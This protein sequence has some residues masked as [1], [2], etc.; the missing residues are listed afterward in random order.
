MKN[1]KNVLGF[2]LLVAIIVLSLLGAVALINATH[3][4]LVILAAPAVMVIVFSTGFAV[5]D[6]LD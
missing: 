1:L 2:V 3:V 4:L 5:A 6:W